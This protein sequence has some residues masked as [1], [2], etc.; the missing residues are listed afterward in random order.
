MACT[1]KILIIG[2]DFNCVS[3]HNLDSQNQ[4]DRASGNAIM[5][6]EFCKKYHLMDPS[7]QYIPLGKNLHIEESY[8]FLRRVFLIL[9]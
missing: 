3:D 7:V 1:H 8:H 6:K 2:G 4:F 9:H 5:L